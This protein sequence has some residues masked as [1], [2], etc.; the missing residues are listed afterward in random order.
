MSPIEN[1]SDSQ[2]TYTYK[3]QNGVTNEVTAEIALYHQVRDHLG[4]HKQNLAVTLNDVA[5]GTGVAIITVNLGEFIGTKDCAY[6]DTNNNPGIEAWLE[7]NRIAKMTGLTKQSGYCTYPLAAFDSDF[8]KS[9]GSD[10]L[11]KYHSQFDHRSIED[12]ERAAWVIRGKGANGDEL[13]FFETHLTDDDLS[14]SGKGYYFA[15]WYQESPGKWTEYD[16]GQYWGYNHTSALEE[17]IGDTIPFR[18]YTYKD[19]SYDCFEAICF[20]NNLEKLLECAKSLGI[21]TPE[22]TR[23][24]NTY[25]VTITETLKRTVTVKANSLEEAQ[26]KVEDGWKYETHVL[27]SKDFAEVHFTA[28]ERKGNIEPER[29]ERE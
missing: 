1:V 21:T 10:K 28:T 15:S 24:E 8:L 5:T 20:E 26:A 17:V 2:K 16:G 22:H 7:E 12:I 6:I 4:E 18:E 9:I 29:Y 19:I 11:A 23:K 3:A 27:D 13:W 25:E 14:P